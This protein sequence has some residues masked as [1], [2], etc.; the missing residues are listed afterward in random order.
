VVA[1]VEAAT[2][3]AAT[4]AAEAAVAVVAVV[5]GAGAAALTGARFRSSHTDLL[6]PCIHCLAVSDLAAVDAAAIAA[7]AV[8]N[9]AVEGVEPPITV[10]GSATRPMLSTPAAQ[11]VLAVVAV[12]WFPA[13]AA[14]GEATA[15]MQAAP[16]AV[17]RTAD[18]A[19]ENV[20]VA[21]VEPVDATT[22]A[23]YQRI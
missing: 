2:P 19:A 5:A 18:A 3:V 23:K 16:I 15:I 10:N 20:A 4:L 14:C 9:A 22:V 13:G 11:N 1:P 17:A 12:G 6:S 7:A 21:S 8:T